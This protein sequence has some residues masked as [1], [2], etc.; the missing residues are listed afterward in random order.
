MGK[1]LRVAA[2][3]RVA[4]RQIAKNIIRARQIF[5]FVSQPKRGN[6]T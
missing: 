3:T 1:K 2:A 4:G 6:A 5:P